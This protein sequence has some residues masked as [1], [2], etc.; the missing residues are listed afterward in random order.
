MK[1]VGQRFQQLHCDA[2]TNNDVSSND[3]DA[4]TDADCRN[5]GKTDASNYVSAMP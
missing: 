5:S 4:D 1:T 3:C 2:D